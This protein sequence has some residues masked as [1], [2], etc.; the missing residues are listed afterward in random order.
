MKTMWQSMTPL[1]GPIAVVIV[2]MAIVGCGSSGSTTSGSGGSSGGSTSSAA[3]ASTAAATTSASGNDCVSKA[4]TLV[5]QQK[6]QVSWGN[7]GPAFKTSAI[8]GKTIYWISLNADIPFTQA[9]FA[10]FK[11][12][13]QQV[14]VKYVF[15]N[16]AGDASK[17]SQGIEQ[18]VAAHADL[19]MIQSIPIPQI[20]VAV[21]DAGKHNI[22]V[23]EAFNTDASAPPD[24]GTDAAVTFDYTKA[25]QMMADDALRISSCKVHAV[26]F[27]TSDEAVAP[28][29]VNGINKEFAMC[30]SAC[31]N[32][33]EDARI[34]DW[35]NKLPIL[36][37][38]AVVNPQINWLM[39]LYDG[40]TQFTDPAVTASPAAATRVKVSSFNATKGIVDQLKSK[41]NP[42]AVDIG[43]PLEWSGYAIADQCFR[44]L[45]GVKPLA[46]ENIP[47][48]TFDK[49]NISSIDLSKPE[50]TWYGNQTDF[51]AEYAKLWGIS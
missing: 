8:K 27:T 41:T 35:S 9:V 32:K 31:S 12:A 3:G 23:V 13:V 37:R 38:N 36:T 34:A 7:P 42:L 24:K 2:S 4:T 17:E 28:D 44:V 10:G 19:I 15:F 39:P 33:V 6:A 25:G 22:P 49:D 16:G 40:E 29:G 30:G 14:G 1:R 46:S 26:T 11:E 18:A 21:A 20:S 45:A 47:L 5:N 51:K 43:S 48:R 50:S